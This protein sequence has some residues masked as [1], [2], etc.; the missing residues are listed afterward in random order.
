MVVARV[1]EHGVLSL[2]EQRPLNERGEVRSECA[3]GC[4][5]VG[6]EDVRRL[7]AVVRRLAGEQGRFVET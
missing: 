2:R 1:K 5:A 7:P 3:D 4:N 6:V